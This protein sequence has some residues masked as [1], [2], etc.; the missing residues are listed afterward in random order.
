[1]QWRTAGCDKPLHPVVRRE[2]WKWL[3]QLD[4]VHLHPVT[5]S[6]GW[7]PTDGRAVTDTPPSPPWSVRH[8]IWSRKTTLSFQVGPEFNL[9]LL[10]VRR[11]DDKLLLVPTDDVRA[12]I[13]PGQ[14]VC[15]Y[16]RVLL[17]T[18]F[19]CLYQ[20]VLLGTPFV[21]LYQRRVHTLP[22]DQNVTTFSWPLRTFLQIFKDLIRPYNPQEMLQAGDRKIW[23]NEKIWGFFIIKNTIKF[24]DTIKFL[25]FFLWLFEHFPKFHDF[26]ST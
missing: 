5:Q 16:Q 18:P 1:M 23:R 14:S 15:L 2:R 22:G 3:V 12:A 11:A 26:L 21:C 19:V 9:I 25:D 24:V 17:G 10:H 6:R 13:G 20:W 8:L 7:V 4:S